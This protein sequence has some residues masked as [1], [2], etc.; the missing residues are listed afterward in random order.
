M[1]L[2]PPHFGR[3]IHYQKPAVISPRNFILL[4]SPSL[5]LQSYFQ[6]VLLLFIYSFFFFNLYDC[7]KNL[8]FVFLC[9]A[10]MPHSTWVWAGLYSS[11]FII[12]FKSEGSRH[13]LIP[14]KF[15]VIIARQNVLP[16]FSSR[17]FIVPCLIVKSLSH[18]QSIFVPA[19]RVCSN[20][21]DWL[22]CPAFPAP[23]A[24]DCL[25]S[26]LY[27][28]LLCLRLIDRRCVGVLP[29]DVCSIPLIHLVIII[30]NGICLQCRR[31]Q[32]DSWVRKIP[33]RRERLPTPIFW[34][35]EFHGLQSMGSQRVRHDWVI[36]TFP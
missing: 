1:S 26:T 13:L 31:P 16:M 11:W 28:L 24:W 30:L 14:R 7:Y 34:P 21:I 3:Q 17:S 27:S 33:W 35:G 6:S 12:L 19:V 18:F 25:F 10:V 23:H 36:F 2:F 5:L 9:S 4:F 20:F 15:L 29:W 32:F 22:G 8:L